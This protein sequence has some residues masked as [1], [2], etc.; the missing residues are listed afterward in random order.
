MR[1]FFL[2][3]CLS[4]FSYQASADT[5]DSLI[6]KTIVDDAMRSYTT[7]CPCPFSLDE[8]GQR[9]GDSSAYSQSNGRD[10]TCYPSD[11]SAEMVA[12]YR[13]EVLVPT[14]QVPIAQEMIR[15]SIAAHP[16]ACA[17]PYQK[18]ASGKRCGLK[19]AYLKRGG[20]RVLCYLHDISQHMVRQHQSAGGR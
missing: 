1:V 2:I 11:V 15:Q 9:C 20:A 12:S 16:G 18:D 6:R 10:R 4:L 7:P 19:A 13:S 17:C 8:Q 3:Y 5:P 14:N